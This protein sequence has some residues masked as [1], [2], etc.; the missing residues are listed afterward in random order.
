MPD[1][2]TVKR[3]SFSDLYLGHPTLGDRFSD[4]PGAD[5]NPLPASS[6]LR[7]DLDQL[8]ALCRETHKNTPLATDFKV[9]H[10][11]VTYR[12]SVMSTLCGAVFVL[13]RIADTISS[14]AELG[15]PQAYIRRLLTKDLSGLLI[16][17]GLIKAGKTMTAC[18]IVKERL[19]AYGGVAVTAEDPVELPLEGSYGAGVCYQTPVTRQSGGLAEA[20]RHVVRWGAKIIFIGEIRDHEVAAEVLQACAGGHLVICTMHAENVIQTITRLHALATEALG[21]AIAQGLLADSLTGVLHQKLTR[22]AKRK[23]ETA[24]VFFKDEPMARTTLRNGKY[25]LLTSDIRQQMANM[26]AENATALRQTEEK[27]G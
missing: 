23:L 2:T 8:T 9:N 27:C 18:S 6:M 22:D 10:D 5:A 11:G 7:N 14:L 17:S 12:V 19:A 26:I 13:R 24:F 4:V 20:F 21:P 16:V 15:I 1:I 25:E 3:L